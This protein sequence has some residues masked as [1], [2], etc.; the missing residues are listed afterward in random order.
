MPDNKQYNEKDF[1]AKQVALDCSTY[2]LTDVQ[3]PVI[4]SGGG[5]VMGGGVDAVVQLA[6]AIKV[7]RP[8]SHFPFLDLAIDPTFW[9]RCDFVNKKTILVSRLRCAPPIF[10]MTPS[11]A[12]TLSGW[13]LLVTKAARLR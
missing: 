6:E 12:P 11:L 13:D 8:I 2:S 1:F 3:N 4:I 9:E 10:T 5:V 7:L